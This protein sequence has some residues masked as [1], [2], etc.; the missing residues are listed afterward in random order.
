MLLSNWRSPESINSYRLVFFYTLAG[1]SST[2]AFLWVQAVGVAESSRSGW[3]HGF[4]SEHQRGIYKGCYKGHYEGCSTGACASV[5]LKLS[6]KCIASGSGAFSDLHPDLFPNRDT[7]RDCG[8][9]LAI[10]TAS[11]VSVRDWE[12]TSSNRKCRRC[13]RCQIQPSK[14]KIRG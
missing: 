1:N 14:Q 12:S 9:A 13:C 5:N 4:L 11:N 7:T 3:R 2:T 10:S 6:E 8:Q